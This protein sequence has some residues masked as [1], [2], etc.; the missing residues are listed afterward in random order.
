MAEQALSA[1]SCSV[2]GSRW[3]WVTERGHCGVG[4]RS[5]GDV[6]CQQRKKKAK[7]AKKKSI[8]SVAAAWRHRKTSVAANVT[9]YQQ[10][11]GISSNAYIK[12]SGSSMAWHSGGDKRNSHGK[13]HVTRHS[14]IEALA[15]A[16]AA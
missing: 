7:N 5:S 13:Q 11:H 15:S 14:A 9:R 16:A 4:T 1:A 12:H 8:V 3:A 2:A 10:Q 6:K